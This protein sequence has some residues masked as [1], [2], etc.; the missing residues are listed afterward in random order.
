M[1]TYRPNSAV[2]FL[3]ITLKK[4]LSGPSLKNCRKYYKYYI[5]I[6]M[7]VQFYSQTLSHRWNAATVVN[8]SLNLT[9]IFSVTKSVANQQYRA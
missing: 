5:S 3:L 4:L 7:F 8:L 6:S 9:V 2:P 1:S